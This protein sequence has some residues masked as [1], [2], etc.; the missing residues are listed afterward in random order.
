MHLSKT[1]ADATSAGKV[2]TPEPIILEVDTQKAREQGIVIMRAGKTV[3]LVD[4][5]PAELLRRLEAA[6]DASPAEAP[7]ES[8]PDV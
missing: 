1:A 8:P 3:Y 7:T 4:Q 6:P 2:R 5:V